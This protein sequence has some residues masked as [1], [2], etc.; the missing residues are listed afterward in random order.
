M[1]D[2]CLKFAD[3]AEAVKVLAQYRATDEHGQ[4]FW[5]TGSHAHALDVIGSIYTPTGNYLLN[6]ETGIAD[7]PEMALAIGFHINLQCE[8]TAG[9]EP[10]I[11]TPLHRQR[12]WA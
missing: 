10:Y 6:P 2:L 5:V 9:L 8:D 11:V 4:P 3:E 1:K 7:I 12:V